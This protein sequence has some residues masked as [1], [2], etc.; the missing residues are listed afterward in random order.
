MKLPHSDKEYE[1]ELQDLKTRIS[2]MGASVADMIASSMR[3]F[4]ERNTELARRMIQFDHQINRFEVETDELCMRILARRQP[5]ASDLRFITT[6]L[7]LVTD[8]ERIGDLCVN[9]C[10][11]V[12]EMNEE[13]PLWPDDL[14]E[15]AEIVE[16]MVREALAAFISGDSD[17]AQHVIERDRVVDV[18]HAQMFRELLTYMTQDPKNVSRATRVQ[19]IARYLERIGDHATN[20]AEMVIF[21]AHGKDIRHLGRIEERAAAHRPHGVL[22]LCTQNSARSQMAEGWARKLLPPGI[23]IWSAGSQ[24]ADRV[25]SYAV[26][27][28]S[29][30]GINISKQYPKRISDVALGD[31]D[32]V[33]TLCADEVCVALPGE[34]QHATW[35]F[36]DPSTVSSSEE[37][38]L[39][40]FRQIRDDLK[41][42]IEA[43]LEQANGR[44]VS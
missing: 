44:G 25:N 27:V 17:R 38:A 15:M 9:I 28:M 39:N 4:V 42:R 34:M 6:G 32:T 20:L 14:P 31:V 40:T 21:M 26:R 35:V 16:G 7:K 43:L 29:E 36:P 37:D 8:L 22:F 10:E 23:R 30:V 41:I 5:V 18:Y 13:E 3:A 2:Q 12:I 11:R 1:S 24:P 33:I 19:F